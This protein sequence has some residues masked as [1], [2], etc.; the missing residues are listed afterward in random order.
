MSPCAKEYLMAM[1]VPFS[2]KGT[3]CVPDLHAFPS[4][5][6]RVKTR[7][8]FSTGTDGNGW[9][10]LN[11]WGN[12][13]N[14]AFVGFTTATYAGTPI[15]VAPSIVTPGLANAL[16]SKMPY[17]NNAFGPSGLNKLEARTVNY[18]L[19][20]RYI[21]PEMARSGQLVG[22]RHPDN[23]TLV[24][25]SLLNFANYSEAKTMRNSRSWSYCLW[26]P[27]KPEEYEFSTDANAPQGTV[28]INWPMGFA[29]IGTTGTTGTLGPASFEYEIISYVEFIGDIDSITQTHVDIQGVSIVRNALP[30]QSAYS[31]HVKHAATVASKVQSSLQAA[32]PA[33][34]GAVAGYQAANYMAGRS[35]QAA[36][37]EAASTATAETSTL[38]EVGEAVWEGVNWGAPIVED[39]AL[40]LLA[41]L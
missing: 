28:G 21:G 1:T 24:G 40:G 8:T 3:A 18:G 2:M 12:S 11:P 17:G 6:V 9:I 7:G 10:V 19:R 31:N 16:Q 37:A 33:V 27:V 32:A 36:A 38:A 35:A 4:K 29:I 14:G 15:V 34:G 5:K 39:V 23:A 20:I 41:V 26:R 22:L 13:N 30:A 25:L